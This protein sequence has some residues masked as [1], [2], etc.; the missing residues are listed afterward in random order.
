MQI[1]LEFGDVATPTRQAKS[2][3]KQKNHSST[4]VVVTPSVQSGRK[5]TPLERRFDKLWAQLEAKQSRQETF[6][7]EVERARSWIHTELSQKREEFKKGLINQTHKLIAHLGKKSL[8]KWQREVLG[9]WIEGNFERIERLG[10]AELPELVRAYY[11]AKLNSLN[12]SERAAMEEYYDESI[13]DIL[14]SVNIDLGDEE[15][16][17]DPEDYADESGEDQS[18]ESDSYY[19]TDDAPD[20]E[21]VAEKMRAAE[22]K[23]KRQTF[24]KSIVN[25]L[26]VR[27]ISST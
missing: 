9:S 13:E 20:Q 10:S 17:D 7:K 4:A 11:T 26:F 18:N 12:K 2:T 16:E 24:D 8:A 27:I 1:E 15:D 23:K 5:A 14:A 25:K 6:E 3:G 22:A 21:S 19:Q